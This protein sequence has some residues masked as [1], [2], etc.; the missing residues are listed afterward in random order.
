MN[1][2]RRLCT[3]STQYTDGIT[4]ALIVHPTDPPPPSL[5]QW[6]EELVVELSDLYHDLSAVLLADYLSVSFYFHWTMRTQFRHFAALW[7]CRNSRKRTS[8]GW[9]GK[10]PKCFFPYVGNE[11]HL[12]NRQLMVW[13]NILRV[14]TEVPTLVFVT[15]S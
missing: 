14:E 3:D 4:G 10:S 12:S 13:V 1:S 5:P 11:K 6:D 2:S 8:S 7:Y 9:W 15:Y